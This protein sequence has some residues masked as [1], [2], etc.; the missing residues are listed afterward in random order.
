MGIHLFRAPSL[1][2][3]VNSAKEKHPAG[4]SPPFAKGGLQQG[5]QDLL[6]RGIFSVPSFHA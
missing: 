6:N 5:Q 3:F 1:R 2:T 4:V